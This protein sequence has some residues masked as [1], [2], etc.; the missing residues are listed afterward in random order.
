MGVGHE[1][2][3]GA[4]AR[5]CVGWAEWFLAIARCPSVRDRSVKGRVLSGIMAFVAAK[6]AI[7]DHGRESFLRVRRPTLKHTG[8][9][10]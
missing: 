7:Q 10:Y 3:I 1:F 2:R 8:G 4:R 6:I 9:S 5:G